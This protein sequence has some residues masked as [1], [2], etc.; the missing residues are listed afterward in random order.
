[1]MSDS[2]LSKPEDYWLVFPSDPGEKTQ[3]EDP[4]VQ[5]FYKLRS[6]K[7]EFYFTTAKRRH[8][9]TRWRWR[10]QPFHLSPQST[11]TLKNGPCSQEA[12]LNWICLWY[13][14]LG[15][16]CLLWVTFHCWHTGFLVHCEWCFMPF[17][18]LKNPER[19]CSAYRPKSDTTR[20]FR[21]TT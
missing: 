2:D 16:T 19:E 9:P 17:S 21:A 20:E 8:K 18:I 15:E 3:V 12:S 4:E 7:H 13:Q 5:K 6:F 10:D 14:L 11:S 1:M